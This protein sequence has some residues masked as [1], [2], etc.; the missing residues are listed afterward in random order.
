[1]SFDGEVPPVLKPL[2]N[3][4]FREDRP[5]PACRPNGGLL[6]AYDGNRPNYVLHR[7]FELLD[8]LLEADAMRDML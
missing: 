1:M 4:S 5:L 2:P 6:S 8:R 3:G 7:E